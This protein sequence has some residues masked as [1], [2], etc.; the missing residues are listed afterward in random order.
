MPRSAQLSTT[1]TSQSRGDRNRSLERGV[2]LL[3]AFR[4]GSDLLGN[5]ELAERTGLARATVSRLTQTLVASGMLEYVRASRA[6]RLG[7]PVLSLAHAMRTGSPALIAAGPLMRAEAERR[8]INVGLAVADGDEMLY[9]ESVRYS[10]RV[11]WRNVVAGQRVPMELT[12]LGRAWL[13]ATDERTRRQL[14]ARFRQRRGEGWPALAPAIAEAIESVRQRG[15][16]WATW[17]PQ[18]VA[19]ATP[20]ALPDHPIYVL[21]MSVSGDTP[22]TEVVERLHGPLMEL[23]GR[24]SESIA[25]G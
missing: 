5:G 18:V 16:C 10:R 15:Y 20:V 7:A 22:A 14:L 8:K 1:G 11:S 13:A 2:A 9:L 6:Y 17:Q 24:V 19:L 21:N 3:R 23:A 25:G 4:P 12:S